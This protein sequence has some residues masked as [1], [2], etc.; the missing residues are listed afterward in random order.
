MS[1]EIVGDAI[2]VLRDDGGV[3]DRQ[4][5]RRF[6]Q[7]HNRIPVGPAR[8]SWAAR[9]RRDENPATHGVFERLAHGNR[10]DA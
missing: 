3:G 6:E 10:Q 5:E 8:R 9:Q 1:A 4:A 7:R 2:L